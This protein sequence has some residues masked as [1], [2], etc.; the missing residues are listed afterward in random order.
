MSK[1]TGFLLK[2]LG[3]HL[4]LATY[5]RLLLEDP[6][7]S[8]KYCQGEINLTY[9]DGDKNH[10]ANFRPIS[11][12]SCICKIYHQILANAFGPVS[13]DLWRGLDSLPRFLGAK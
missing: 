5:S 8:T 7:P 4:F 11:L 9:K 3:T 6:D 2:L 1:C 12:T 13:H 10:A